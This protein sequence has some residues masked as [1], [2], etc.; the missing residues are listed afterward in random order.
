MLIVCACVR[1][2]DMMYSALEKKQEF[3]DSVKVAR[4]ERAFEK[5][6]E[7]SAILLQARIRGWLARIN[8]RKLVLYDVSSFSFFFFTLMFMNLFCE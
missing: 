1:C 5:R 4:E 2:V 6:K 8:Y 3:L 7:N